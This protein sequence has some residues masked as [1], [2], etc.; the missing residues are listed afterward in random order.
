MI[1]QIIIYS[2]SKLLTVCC[3]PDNASES[4]YGRYA[5][6]RPN[7]EQFCTELCESLCHGNRVRLRRKA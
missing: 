6:I 1:A 2:W 7:N 3:V 5:G 4:M